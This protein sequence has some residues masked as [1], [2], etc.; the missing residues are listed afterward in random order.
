MTHEEMAHQV[1]KPFRICDS[2]EGGFLWERVVNVIK[3]AVAEEREA[4]AKLLEDFLDNPI[5]VWCADCRHYLPLPGE[6]GLIER[7]ARA[8]RERK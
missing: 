6:K 5:R 2:V 4:C 1:I 8:I 7:H 3:Q